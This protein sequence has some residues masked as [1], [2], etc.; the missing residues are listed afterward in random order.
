MNHN[1][2]RNVYTTLK[3]MY[4]LECGYRTDLLTSSQIT[5]A[6]DY[7]RETGAGMVS[8]ILEVERA[9]CKAMGTTP[10][11]GFAAWLA[12]YV[13][14]P[15]LIDRWDSCEDS[16]SF[17]G[18]HIRYDERGLLDD[19]E[20]R[21]L[22]DALREK[23]GAAMNIGRQVYGAAYRAE[24]GSFFAED[25]VQGYAADVLRMMRVNPVAVS[26]LTDME[27][28]NY[29]DMLDDDVRIL[30][31]CLADEE[32][33]IMRDN[34]AE[35]YEPSEEGGMYRVWLDATKLTRTGLWFPSLGEFRYKAPVEG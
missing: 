32:W 1:K 13:K 26:E 22:C 25:A 24:V 11:F 15:S 12:E 4:D 5:E 16:V 30:A 2:L 27:S 31:R 10:V 9:Y 23:V 8:Q 6:C 33:S 21:I 20:K 7:V 34:E 17:T 3:H 14:S 35:D 28:E 18:R 19:R 29:A